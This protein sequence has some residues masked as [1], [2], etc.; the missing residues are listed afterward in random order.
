LAIGSVGTV[1]AVGGGHLEI[2]RVDGVRRD[3]RIRN[4]T[5]R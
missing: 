2:L 1:R 3:Q 5:L 4:E